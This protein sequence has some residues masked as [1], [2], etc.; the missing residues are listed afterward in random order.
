MAGEDL[1]NDPR[2]CR[3]PRERAPLVWQ[4]RGRPPAGARMVLTTA[5][6]E[7]DSSTTGD[8]RSVAHL[9]SG[10]YRNGSLAY[11]R[12][13]SKYRWLRGMR[14]SRMSDTRNALERRSLERYGCGCARNHLGLEF[15]W[16]AA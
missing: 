15:A 12:R 8:V 3:P 14:C 7:E 4:P 13:D 2:L 5:A 16:A 6:G 1:A 10:Q 9:E 11:R